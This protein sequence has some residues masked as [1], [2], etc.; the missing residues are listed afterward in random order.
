MWAYF[1]QESVIKSYVQ[2]C[3]IKGSQLGAFCSQAIVYCY[4]EYK[5][6]NCFQ[7]E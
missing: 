1:Y 5:T 2:I 7:L 3:L 4:L 6:Q